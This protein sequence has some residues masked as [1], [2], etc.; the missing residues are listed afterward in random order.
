MK[1]GNAVLAPVLP[2]SPNNAS[3]T[4]PGTIGLTTQLYAAMNEQ[5]ADQLI[6]S[7]FRNIVLMGDH[8][9]GQK[10][11]GEVASELDN[12]YSGKGIHVVY[13]DQVYVGT[14][15]HPGAQ[16]DFEQWLAT[17]GYPSGGHAGVSDT[18]EMM[19]PKQGAPRVRTGN[20]YDRRCSRLLDEESIALS[21]GFG[22]AG[23]HRDRALPSRH[24]PFGG[25]R[26]HRPARRP[27]GRDG[28]TESTAV[29]NLVHEHRCGGAFRVR[30]DARADHH[31]GSPQINATHTA[32]LSR[33][34]PCQQ[35]SRACQPARLQKM[36]S[37]H[38]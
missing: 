25:D 3:A 30:Q 19:Y 38:G 18:S 23:P 24:L 2:Y 21:P 8:G 17:N 28:Q 15:E 27:N 32:S 29:R 11:L 33:G 22:A 5:I 6:V 16:A 7:G 12:K 35:R 1:L 34:F 37:I 14:K 13:Y 9:G 20:P 26:D 4:L 10:E 31:S 36:S